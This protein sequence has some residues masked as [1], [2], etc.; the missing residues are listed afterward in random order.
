MTAMIEWETLDENE[1]REVINLANYWLDQLTRKQRIVDLLTEL[2]PADPDKSGQPWVQPSGAHDV[3]GLG[4]EA[5]H[6][7]H[8]WESDHPF[9]VWEPGTGDLW[10]D[11]GEASEPD[12][13]PLDEYP[14]WEPDIT[15]KPGDPY[16]YEGGLYLA[17]QAHKTQSDWTPDLT[18]ALWKKV[19]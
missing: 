4:A 9:N 2:N 13:L 16:T 18:P 6:K 7:G 19:S 3:Y 1:L 11:K 17:L 15:V 5:V 10:I 14:A 12:P 8:L